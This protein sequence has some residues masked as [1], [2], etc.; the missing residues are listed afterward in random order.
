M[1]KVTK[2][3]P[4]QRLTLERD[5]PRI[6]SGTGSFLLL[7]ASLPL[8]GYTAWSAPA[9]FAEGAELSQK[10]ALLVMSVAWCALIVS[11]VRGMRRRNQWPTGLDADRAAGELRLRE[12][13]RLGRA[14]TEE[15]IPLP[16]LVSLKVRRTFLAPSL[17]D[18][19]RPVKAGPGIALSFS[20]RPG[21][22]AG[23]PELR[24][25]RFGVQDLDRVEEVADFALRLGGAAGLG[26]FRI[27]RSDLRDV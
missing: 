5:S 15:I 17:H 4:G 8:I 25:L 26:F 24:E 21:G 2:D 16:H 27:V 7:A 11:T 3:V 20:L 19:L 23:S 12:A 18:P 9:A 6:P 14:A 13:G 22:G 10:I 1:M